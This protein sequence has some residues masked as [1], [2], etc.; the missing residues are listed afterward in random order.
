MILAGIST[1]SGTTELV[2]VSGV[3][4]GAVDR[5]ESGALQQAS[6]DGP[7]AA[8]DD[9]L[10]DVNCS[11]DINAA[12]GLTAVNRNQRG[13]EVG[14]VR[15]SQGGGL[16]TVDENQVLL[17]G[18]IYDNEDIVFALPNAAYGT[19][20][21]SI[22]HRHRMCT[23][24]YKA[25]HSHLSLLAY[26]SQSLQPHRIVHIFMLITYGLLTPCSQYGSDII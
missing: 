16:H 23:P 3:E 2:A 4:G 12:Y 1:T 18:Y 15:Q 17:E 21:Q 10:P 7:S 22:I 19:A 20:G 24:E 26:L 14:D 5:G 13:V 8:E 6:K 9:R 11:T 25:T